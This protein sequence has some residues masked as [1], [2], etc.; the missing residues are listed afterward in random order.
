LAT[1]CC[2]I[3][4][5]VVDESGIKAGHA[6][7]TWLANFC[8]RTRAQQVAQQEISTEKA[9]YRSAYCSTQAVDAQ[10]RREIK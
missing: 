10:L 3:R 5:L 4:R 7:H 9:P 6:K 8:N 1:A 2:D